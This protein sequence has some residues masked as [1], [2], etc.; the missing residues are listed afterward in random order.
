MQDDNRDCRE[1]EAGFR[2]YAER[3]T[4]QAELTRLRAE[5]EELRKALGKVVEV[6]GQQCGR[7]FESM[8]SDNPRATLIDATIE[9]AACLLK[10]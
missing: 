4:Q 5:N 9:V 7:V 3:E 1:E 6:W 8:G 2:A 10:P